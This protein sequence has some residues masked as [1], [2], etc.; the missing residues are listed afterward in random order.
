MTKAWVERGLSLPCSEFFLSILNTYGLQPHNICPNSYLLVSSFATLCEGHL[1]IRPDVRLWQFFFRVKKTKDKAMLNCGSMTFMLRPGRMYP[2]HDSHESVRYWN[3]GWFYEKNASVPEVHDGLP[4]FVNE[5]PEELA[6]WSF[7][8]SLAQAPILEKAARRISWLVHDGLTGA[9][10]T[11]SWF[12]RRIQPLRYNARLI[13]AYTGADDLLRAT[14]HDLPADSLKRRIKTLVKIGRGQPVPELIKDIHTNNQCP[15]AASTFEASPRQSFRLEAGASGEA[16]AKKPKITKP[17]LNSKKAERERLKMLATA[18][19]R[20]RPIIP[21]AP[22]PTTAATRTTSQEPIT[23]Y[24]KKSPA[25][26][27]PTPTPPSTSHTAPP[28]S[29][30][31]AD[32][33]P[34]PAANTPPEIIPVSSE[35]AGG[36][37]P[38][39]KGPAQDETEVQGQGEAEVTSSEKIGAGAG[40]VVVFPK[41]FGDPADLTSTP[42]AYAT[43]FFNKLTKAEKWE[44]EQDLLNA[45]LNNAWGKPDAATSEIQDFKKDVGQFFD[46]LICKQKEQQA[47]HYELHKNIAL[48]RRVTLGILFPATTSSELE[49]LR[50]SYQ[51]LETK[52]MEAEQ[53]K[54]QAEKLA[55]KTPSSSRK[56]RILVEEKC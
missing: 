34:P 44:L 30:P 51:E 21:G 37:D 35:K 39:A 45:M 54:E 10:L 41:N 50:S 23:K 52:L 13:Y 38:K 25:V 47:L 49:N 27:P 4:K 22:V 26:G 36:E 43:K 46:K 55:E 31:Q 5:P 6:S 7:V 33:S 24:M 40:D 48:Q 29:P 2:P 15:P 20:S 56:R 16:S 53:K 12:T 11:L 17:P 28:P 14:R 42:K 19:K 1:G 9:Q 18:G 8:P 3:A 32:Q